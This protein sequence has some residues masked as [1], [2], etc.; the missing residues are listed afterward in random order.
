[1]GR[2]PDNLLILAIAAA[3][4]AGCASYPRRMAKVKQDFVRGNYES[5]ISDISDSD[6]EGGKDQI[7]ALLERAILKQS[8]G[9]FEGSNRDFEAAYAVMEDYEN[10]PSVSLRDLSSEASAALVNDTALPYK[11]TGYE[12]FLLH[13][14]KALNFLFLGD[15]EGAGVEIRRLDRRREIELETNRRARAAAEEAAREE[16]ISRNNLDGIE[17][18]LLQAYG[19]A[20]DRAA[21]VSNLYLSA[22][23]SYLSALH[24]DLE[25]NWSEALIDYR[26]ILEQVPSSRSARFD[27]VSSGAEDISVPAGG[28]DLR[29]AGDLFLVFQS[30]LSPVKDQV[31]IPIPVGDGVLALAFPFY[32]TVPTRL[33]RAAVSIDG[34]DAGTTEILSDIEAKQI[35]EL[36]DKIPVLIVRQAIRAAVKAT[37]LHV[38]KKEGGVWGEL[39]ASFYNIFSEQADLRSWLLLPQNIQVLRVYPPAGMRMVRIDLLDGGGAVLDSVTLELEFRNDQTILLNLRAVGYTPLNPD[40]LTVTQQWRAIPRVPLSSRPRTRVGME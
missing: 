26:R 19:P 21:S 39:A 32:R 30:G 10:R 38:A 8:L 20:R 16:K 5:A 13:I 3:V 18:Q 12:K 25:G 29:Q 34:R 28:L 17:R 11:G 31:Y 35:R 6:C 36:I 33:E 2:R 1:M 23:G 7:L 14:Y 22:F 9:D 15:Y 24:Y 40:G 37:M 4:L 27:A